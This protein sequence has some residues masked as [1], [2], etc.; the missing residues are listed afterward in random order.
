[1]K[2]R[3]ITLSAI[4]LSSQLLNAQDGDAIITEGSYKHKS[5]AGKH[6]DG[7]LLSIYQR[8]IALDRLSEKITKLLD[9]ANIYAYQEP[10]FKSTVDEFRSKVLAEDTFLFSL[11]NGRMTFEKDTGYINYSNSGNKMYKLTD[12]TYYHIMAKL[13][14]IENEFDTKM[15]EIANNRSDIKFY[16][17]SQ[18]TAAM[19]EIK[20]L[21]AEVATLSYTLDDDKYD[22][23]F[24]DLFTKIDLSIGQQVDE[25][26]RATQNLY[27]KPFDR[28][29]IANDRVKEESIKNINSAIDEFFEDIDMVRPKNI[30]LYDQSIHIEESKALQ[31]LTED[32]MK[33][34]EEAKQLQQGARLKVG[35]KGID[36]DK[37]A[38]LTQPKEKYQ[39][40]REEMMEKSETAPKKTED[41]KPKVPGLSGSGTQL[42]G[43]DGEANDNE[44]LIEETEEFRLTI[45]DIDSIPFPNVYGNAS[46]GTTLSGLSGEGTSVLDETTSSS[47]IDFDIETSP[48]PA[49]SMEGETSYEGRGTSGEAGA[50]T[51]GDMMTA[52]RVTD[53]YN[54]PT[55]ATFEDA[56]AGT[57]HYEEVV[58]NFFD[59]THDSGI[60]S[61]ISDVISSER[62][63]Q[64]SITDTLATFGSVSAN[65]ILESGMESDYIEFESH[66]TPITIGGSADIVTEEEEVEEEIRTAER[67]AAG[68]LDPELATYAGITNNAPLYEE[69]V[70]S[71][72]DIEGPLN[73]E[74]IT[75]FSPV[76][77]EVEDTFV[78]ES[79]AE[80]VNYESETDTPA[81]FDSVTAGTEHVLEENHNYVDFEQNNIV[82]G[83][84]SIIEETEETDV[85][86]TYSGRVHQPSVTDTEATYADV[87]ADT[88]ISGHYYT[89]IDEYN[90]NGE[91]Y[92]GGYVTGDITTVEDE[93]PIVESHLI[94]LD[95]KWENQQSVQ[96]QLNVTE[97]EEDTYPQAQTDMF[98]YPVEMF[99][100]FMSPY[101]IQ[102]KQIEL[103]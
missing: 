72:I 44:E 70:E 78:T 82:S 35:Y 61:G 25:K 59:I 24:D 76:I 90:T 1:M 14:T 73:G 3:F 95:S 11:N 13:I 75:G 84:A 51:T 92:M 74:T 88:E 38:E 9:R 52:S 87:A 50:P 65:D 23:A 79:F 31:D 46:S 47:V 17:P 15:S 20:K 56:T 57:V 86:E 27:G 81:T 98:G 64:P 33:K 100:Q 5:E 43:L 102:C 12:Q 99:N 53:N 69:V 80:R 36:K 45:L 60:V 55:L 62:I 94:E 7:T 29:K 58:E 6:M 54:I 19:E 37:L 8:D 97:V 32:T 103:R 16:T 71:Y 10:E 96:G 2:K 4:M 91:Q 63:N 83:Q 68:Y 85:E 30:T 93:E 48:V 49:P 66:S 89:E 28:I 41:I 67:I 40:L 42:K 77:E 21:E 18:R 26:K 39:K 34:I 22:D 101:E